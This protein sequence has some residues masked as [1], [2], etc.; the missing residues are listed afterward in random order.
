MKRPN[1]KQIL[2]EQADKVYK[3][4]LIKDNFNKYLFEKDKI[5]FYKRQNYYKNLSKSIL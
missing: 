5:D 1:N 2:A 4:F 3:Q